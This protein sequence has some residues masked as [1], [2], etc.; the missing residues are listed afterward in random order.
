MEL[1]QVTDVSQCAGC[2]KTLPTSELK[3]LGNLK[4]CV[5]CYPQAQL[6]IQPSRPHRP[7]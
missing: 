5:H 6:L 4:I 1:M 2:L 3:P 7:L